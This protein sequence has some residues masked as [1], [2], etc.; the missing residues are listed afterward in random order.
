MST[1]KWS[2]DCLLL[3]TFKTAHFSRIVTFVC[4]PILYLDFTPFHGLQTP[5]HGQNLLLFLNLH[6]FS[7]VQKIMDYNLLNQIVSDAK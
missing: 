6:I 2:H 5:F 3:H 4:N 7:K 1:V